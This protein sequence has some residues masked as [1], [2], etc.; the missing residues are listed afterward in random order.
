MHPKIGIYALTL[1]VII[2]IAGE[3]FVI[4]KYQKPMGSDTVLHSQLAS[5]LLNLEYPYGP[6]YPYPPAF[7]FTI[8]VLSVL[9]LAD[10]LQIISA[11]QVIM[12]SSVIL[13]TY[14]LLYKKSDP[15]ASILCALLLASSPAFW[16]RAS[17]AIP[18]AVDLLLF[19]L[20]FYFYLERKDKAF[21]GVSTFA[22]YNHFAYSALPIAGL[23]LHSAL[24]GGDIKKFVFVALLSLPLAS[25]MAYN[26]A[27]IAAESS[28]M[29]SSQEMA[30]LGEPLFAIKYLGYPLFFLLF[31]VGVRLRFKTAT[32]LEGVLLIWLMSLL[33]LAMYFPDRLVQYAAQP[34]AMLGAIALEGY[35]KGDKARLALL[36]G[37]A[38]FSYV[39]LMA[40]Y[41]AQIL[42]GDVLIPLDSLSPFVV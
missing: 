29:Q 16:D 31:A 18:Q 11:L 10:P 24:R 25:F 12:F 30:V 3:T 8:A 32:D 28:G 37:L 6:L 7:H 34:L 26:Y 36:L 35:I 15:F 23:F 41:R 39:S 14:Y 13:S 2:S 5:K 9:F 38:L 22:V 17:Q 40:F 1:L 20:I 21:I 42:N 19:P 33:P 4:T 27:G